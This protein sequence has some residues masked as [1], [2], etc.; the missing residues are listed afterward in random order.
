MRCLC[1]T[2]LYCI[3]IQEGGGVTAH[4]PQEEKIQAIF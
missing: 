1:F 4:F 2:G 3:P